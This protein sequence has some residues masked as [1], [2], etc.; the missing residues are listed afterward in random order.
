MLAPG[1]QG[2][3]FF[4]QGIVLSCQSG[5]CD[6][7][8]DCWEGL[9]ARR[10]GGLLEESRTASVE[11]SELAEVVQGLGDLPAQAT[12][13]ETACKVGPGVLHAPYCGLE[14]LG[15][16]GA[17]GELTCQQDPENDSG[18]AGNRPEVPY[19]SLPGAGDRPGQPVIVIGPL[20][21]GGGAVTG[22]EYEQASLRR[23]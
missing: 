1:V 22:V 8:S 3:K 17:V 14:C 12:V 11:H 13:S 7:S 2:L 20:G 15:E 6:A 10:C 21:V 5:R 9:N 19:D 23:G 4:K 18:S 16:A